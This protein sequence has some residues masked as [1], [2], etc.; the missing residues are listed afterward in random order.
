MSQFLNEVLRYRVHHQEKCHS[1]IKELLPENL[2]PAF[3]YIILLGHDTKPDYK[4]VKLWLASC[5]EDE[6][7]A[8]KSKLVIHNERMA[9]DIL[10]DHSIKDARLKPEEKK[11]DN[12]AQAPVEEEEEKEPIKDMNE[13]YEFDCDTGELSTND[14]PIDINFRKVDGQKVKK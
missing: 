8:F 11:K 13:S 2:V 12:N 4:L 14:R 10:Y 5:K 9:K 3:Q 6:K 7:H 1:R